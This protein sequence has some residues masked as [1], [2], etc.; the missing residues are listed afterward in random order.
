MRLFSPANTSNSL[1][2]PLEKLIK[3][4]NSQIEGQC[5]KL[6]SL[7]SQSLVITTGSF[8]L[9]HAALWQFGEKDA[10]MNQTKRSTRGAAF[11]PVAL[12]H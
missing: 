12:D 1:P 10:M 9:A 8:G 4:T 2:G 3:S 5:N 7:S 11:S 6:P